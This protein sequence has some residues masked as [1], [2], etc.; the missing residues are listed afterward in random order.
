MGLSP[1]TFQT[2]RK[3]IAGRHTFEH[4]KEHVSQFVGVKSVFILAQPFTQRLGF[5]DDMIN[6][7]NAI[8]IA[9]D[10]S[11][12]VEPE[13]TVGNIN[14]LF[15]VFSGQPY[16]LIIAM[17]GGSVLDAAKV[18]SVLKTNDMSVEEMTGI[19]KIPNPGIPTVMI[20]TTAG[21]GSE[22]TPNAI[23]T[24]PEEELKIG[25][26]GRHLLPSLVIMD[27]VITKSLPPAIT[28]AT[29]M[30][31]FTH[32]LES[33]ISNKANPISDMYALESMRLI[34]GSIV[35]SYTQGDDVDAREAM[36]I[37]SMYGGMALTSAG[38]A[39]VHALAYP[40][41]GKF[42][43]THGVANSMLLPHVMRFNLD[44]ITDR[45]ARAADIMLSDGRHS[46][47]NEA[48][49]ERVLAQIEQWTKTL[50]IPQDLTIYGVKQE[51]VHELAVAA[52]KVTRLMDNNP[53]VMQIEDIEN[54]YLKLL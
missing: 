22:V 27:P 46:D 8:G 24:F 17:G 18:L 49:A 2:A 29:G 34:A 20:P 16:D 9:A 39:A 41:G 10:Y 7:L 25:I 35:T 14:A 54:V 21:T 37:G 42:K 52:S 5:L 3:I 6:Q 1:Y 53:K 33:F 48:K 31:A 11:V 12:D 30:D 51:D 23:V 26:V 28:A 45:L 50:H 13:P 38:T 44:A 19:E 40:I 15:E 47:S 4:L 32:A 43:V 36:L